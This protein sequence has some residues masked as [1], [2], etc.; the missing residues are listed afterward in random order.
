MDVDREIAIMAA[1]IYAS[2]ISGRDKDVYIDRPLLMRQAIE[3][4][5]ALWALRS[6][7]PPA[8]VSP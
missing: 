3:E 2:K 8:W 4:A 5:L 7:K 1:P 6:H